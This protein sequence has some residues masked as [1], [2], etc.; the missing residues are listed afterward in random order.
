MAIPSSAVRWVLDSPQ[1]MTIYRPRDYSDLLFWI[2]MIAAVVIVFALLAIFVKRGAFWIIPFVLL[3]GFFVVHLGYS[4]TATAVASKREG[5]LRITDYRGVTNTYPLQSV[6]KIAVETQDGDSR[7]M[8]FVLSTGEDVPLG[9]WAP[10]KGLYQAADA[11]N[12]FL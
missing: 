6:Q 5:T 3:I 9:M 8:V 2:G 4:D 10:R 7:R 12:S 1:Q 11:F